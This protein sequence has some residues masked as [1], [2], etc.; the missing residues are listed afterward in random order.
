VAE[1]LAMPRATVQQVLH[2]AR[3]RWGRQTWM[4]ELR[5]EI[6]VLLDK[7]GGV[8]TAEEVA[9][10]VLTARGSAAPE[11][12]RSRFAAAVAIAAVE[13]EAAREGARYTPYRGQQRAFIVAMPGLADCYTAAPTARAQYAEQLAAKADALAQADPLLAPLR[14]VEELQAVPP[15]EGDPTLTPDRL[16][17]LAAAAAQHAALS[18]RMELYPRGMAAARALKLGVGALLGPKELTAQHIQQRIASRYPHAEPVPGR[19]ALD[20]LLQEAGIAWVWD[21]TGAEGKGAYRPKYRPAD[22]PAR[23]STLPRL[24]TA[25]PP[26]ASLSPEIEAAHI[27]EERLSRAVHEH[28][29][30]LL[31]VAPRHLLRA[32]AEIVRRFPVLRL[33]LEALLLQAMQATAAAV[34]ARWEVV[35]QADAA[36]HDSR[37]WRNLH[38][39]VRRAMPAVEQA[40]FAAERPVLLV[41]PGLLARYDQLALL[42]KLRDACAQARHVPGFIVLIAADEQH[43]LPVLDGRPVPVVVASEWA[44]L[45]EAWLTNAHRTQEGRG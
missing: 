29:F 5:K 35:L 12:D 36:S 42:E 41:Y 4:T 32:E 38:T 19:P 26:G 45:P 6:A 17:R 13:T 25:A 2:Q 30:L 43:P 8:M 24:S 22:T 23:T 27:L 18:S 39:L 37:D 44:R 3:Q 20:E 33:S 31:T 14:V 7:S 10:A 1:R 11:P 9:A 21:D 34:G 40:L 28:R 16:L 15:P